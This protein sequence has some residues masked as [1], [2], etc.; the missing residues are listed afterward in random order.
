[1]LFRR[2][3]YYALLVGLLSGLVVTVVQ[4]W[5]VVPIIYSAEVFENNALPEDSHEGHKHSAGSWTPEYGLERTAYTFLSNILTATG[6]AML[7]LAAM[8]VTRKSKA[9]AKFDW[10]YGLGWSM[11]GYVV[12]FLAPALGLP[13]EIPLATLAPVETRQLWW[14]LT[15]ACTSAAIAGL[16]FGKAPWRW[17]APL[18][19]VMPYLIM[20]PPHEAV[21]M[22]ANQPPDVATE[23]E[24]LAKQF[25]SATAITNAILW[26][27][28]GLTSAWAIGRCSE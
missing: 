21:G 14:L 6:F 16:V 11:A 1:M 26:L 20:T 15:V 12:F 2:I 17:I 23:L 9:G 7:I 8:M 3:I 24:R 5:Q 22:F 10:R 13:P 4:F 28:L 18:L 27:V 19:L 25:I